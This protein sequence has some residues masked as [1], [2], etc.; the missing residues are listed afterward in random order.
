M[1]YETPAIYEK[2]SSLLQEELNVHDTDILRKQ[3]ASLETMSYELSATRVDWLVKLYKARERFR[4]PKGTE[5]T[6][7]D[8]KTMLDASTTDIER[9]YLFLLSLEDI[10]KQRIE[11][12]MIILQTI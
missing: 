10:V 7:F 5:Y 1:H 12:G 9:D 4:M 2:I 8:R 3:L 11:L 6:E